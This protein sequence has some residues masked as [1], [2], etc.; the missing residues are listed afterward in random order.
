ML[1]SILQIRVNKDNSK[2]WIVEFIGNLDSYG[3]AERRKEI[4]MAVDTFDKQYLVFD[5]TRL[6]YIN[7]ESIGLMLQINET[8]LARKQELVL[9]RAKKNVIDVLEVIGL[10]ETVS[11]F[12][13]LDE[14]LKKK[15]NN[16]N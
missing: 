16:V 6:E 4:M 3:L 8:L 9:V 14:F 10:L 13:D 12:Q 11:Y 1:E 5:F 7:S 15:L 2:Y